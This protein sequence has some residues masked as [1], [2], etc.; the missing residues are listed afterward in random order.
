M[1]LVIIDKQQELKYK[2]QNIK[3]PMIILALLGIM[4]KKHKQKWDDVILITG[5]VGTAKSTM[6]QII[7]GLW[8]YMHD[9]DLSIENFT[10]SAKGVT[11]FIDK[12]G[13]DNEVIIY[14]EAITGGTGRASLTK[15]GNT[16]KIGLVV[17]RRKRH[18]YIMIIDELLEFSK[19]II[20]RSSLLID[21]RTL[22][23]KGEAKRGYFKIYNPKEI[24]ELYWML[25]EN[26]IK[27]ISHYRSKAKPFF[28]FRD[29]S[30]IFIN[31]EQYEEKK[32]QETKQLQENNGINWSEIKIKTFYYWS[33][34]LKHKD[35]N[36]KTGVSVGTIKSWSANEFKKVVV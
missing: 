21:M 7:G 26:K 3:V 4:N 18:I 8:Q 12:E 17:G 35:I 24:R 25:K 19:K 2:G 30:N 14:D 34:G 32:I 28:K 29:L 13:N 10:W 23:V 16:L 11:D 27:Y 15:E 9:K 36:T 1:K 5:N 20:S 22:M 33:Q 6:G 31:E